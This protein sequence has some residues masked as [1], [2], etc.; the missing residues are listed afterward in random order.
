M[1]NI[2]YIERLQADYER[3]REA[4]KAGRF[5]LEQRLKEIE[6]ATE[7]YKE[8]HAEEYD[9]AVYKA[10]SEGKSPGTVPI[11][12]KDTKL[13]ERLADLCMD[14]YL[15]WSHPDKMTIVED[16]VL[17]G[18]QRWERILDERSGKWAE[19]IGTDGVN[20]EPQT[21]DYLRRLNNS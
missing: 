11:P 6:E 4:T 17:T 2:T 12:F 10:V 16:P 21:R 20:H 5:P 18:S 14:E 3:I 7:R 15:R 1:S 8:S 9:N 13:L 19:N